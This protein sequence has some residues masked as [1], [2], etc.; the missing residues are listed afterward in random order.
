MIENTVGN[1]EI[2]CYEQ[3]LLFPLCFQKACFPG[4]SKGVILWEWVKEIVDRH[5]TTYKEKWQ[6]L[7]LTTLCSGELKSKHCIQIHNRMFIFKHSFHLTSEIFK[8]YKSL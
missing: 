4:A 3:F 2:T 6:L 8:T 7:T 5:M 1:G